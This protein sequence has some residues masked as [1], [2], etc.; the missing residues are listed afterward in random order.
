MHVFIR[1]KIYAYICIHAEVF[2]CGESDK[3]IQING[4]MH[5]INKKI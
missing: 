5:K 3:M 1:I 2:D 4:K